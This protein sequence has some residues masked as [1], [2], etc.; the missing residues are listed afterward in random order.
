MINV[1]VMWRTVVVDTK[2]RFNVLMSRRQSLIVLPPHTRKKA[3]LVT[4]L[5]ASCNMSGHQ[6]DIRLLVPSCWTNLV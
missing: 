4:D 1:E 6:A 3:Q 5:Q 2:G